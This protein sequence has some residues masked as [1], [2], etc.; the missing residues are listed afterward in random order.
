ME[1]TH[2]HAL[3]YLSV[4]RRRKWWLT[5]PII[6]SIVV[7]VLLVLFLPKQY[8]SSATVAVQAP[9][10]SPNLITQSAPLDNE[11]RIRAVSQQLL[12][13]AV[14]TRVARDEGLSATPGDALFRRLRLAVTISV[15]EPVATTSEPRRFDSFVVSYV[16]PDPAMAQRVTNRLVSVF[17]DENSRTRTQRAEQTASFLANQVA[18]S[19]ARLENLQSRL[20]ASK[21]AHIGQLPEQTQANL[22]TLGGLRQQLETNGVALRGEQD[23]LSMVDRQVAAMLQPSPIAGQG[24]TSIASGVSLT[25]ELKVAALEHDLATA[26]L[27][28]TDKHPEVI[29]L[30]EELKI[31]R[32][33]A[34]AE[35]KR[36]V[37]DRVA[38]LQNEPAYRQLSGER[39]A[40]RLRVREL[41]GVEG[42]LR[43]QIALYQSRVES[44]P[45]VE[46]QLASV[47]RDY[48]LEKTQYSE[49]TA[50]LR[51]A[52]TAENVEQ[53]GN[54]EQ[55]SVLYGAAYPLEP[56]KPIPLRV[57]LLSIV[58][59][60]CLG[61]VSMLGREYFDRSVHD[62]RDLRDE[63]DLSVLGTVTRIKA[64]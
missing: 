18:A 1:D 58:A 16:D 31:A 35:R 3:D 49:L 59:G 29:R 52:A 13:P 60:I 2:V 61:G 63:L 57:M 47:Q 34:A 23:R 42:G 28:Y 50:K 37:S 12:S 62:V 41:E 26:R 15:P 21:E 36:P 11:E 55:F 17:V 43:R 53:R 8:K 27:S 40:A 19:Q 4:L 45:M 6:A 25:P 24:G 33:R 44:A 30:T 56:S 5:A 14:L 54:G 46:E 39:D 38:A 7:G 20:R 64:A 51:A 32:E 9:A 48:D 10:I 22:Q